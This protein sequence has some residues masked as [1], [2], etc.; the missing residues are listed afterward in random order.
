MATIRSKALWV[1]RFSDNAPH[2]SSAVPAGSVWV[3]RQFQALNKIAGTAVLSLG[4][5]YG[6]LFYTL[7]VG[8]AV[9]QWGVLSGPFDLVVNAG[10]K[11][12]FELDG[13]SG[14]AGV[15]VT[16]SGSELGP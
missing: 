6:S 7:A 4:V 2:T 12:W 13:I 11:L 3:V 14:G 10:G 15:D 1:D 16:A 9:P 8:T 5:N